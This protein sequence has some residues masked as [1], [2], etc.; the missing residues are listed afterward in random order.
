MILTSLIHS[1]AQLKEIAISPFQVQGQSQPHAQVIFEDSRGFIWLGR[2][3][4]LYKYN[5]YNLIRY[6]HDPADSTSLSEN[7]IQTIAED[8]DG[9]LWI[10]TSR[11]LNR[12][13]PA[14]GVCEHFYCEPDSVT[15]L[16]DN[17]ISTV[18]I[19]Q[20]NVVWTGTPDSGLNKIFKLKSGVE[21]NYQCQRYQYNSDNPNSISSNEIYVIKEE[22]PSHGNR[23]WI[24]TANGLNAFDRESGRFMHFKHDP[25]DKKTISDNKVWSLYR[26]KDG[27]LWIGTG[28]G[29]LNKLIRSKDST[30][31]FLSFPW[32]QNT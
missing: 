2:Y 11:G 7:D 29:G 14:N 4:G 30:I 16:S 26:D 24:G 18:F 10:G 32:G 9:F 6:S 31:T 25:Q 15:S 3:N 5:G 8:K 23:L 1:F 28:G 22:A 13:N 20:F 12:F 19:D 27:D 17:F 21:Q